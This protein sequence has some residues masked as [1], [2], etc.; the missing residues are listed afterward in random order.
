[1][2]FSLKCNFKSDVKLLTKIVLSF[3]AVFYKPLIHLLLQLPPGSL[4]VQALECSH[5]LAPPGV[6]NDIEFSVQQSI[7]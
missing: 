7:S 6:H 3:N 2:Q 4:S 1:M 5:N